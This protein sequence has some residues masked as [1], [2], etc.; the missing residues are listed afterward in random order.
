MLV[1]RGGGGSAGGKIFFNPTT[2]THRHFLLSLVSLT[3][4][5]QDG[6][7]P[8]SPIDIYDHTE[9]GDCEECFPTGIKVTVDLQ[10]PN[11]AKKK[12]FCAPDI[13]KTSI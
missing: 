6:G 1:K 12:N 13:A 3:S 4:R 8:N 9:K 5:D 2:R 7:Q 10:R 11:F